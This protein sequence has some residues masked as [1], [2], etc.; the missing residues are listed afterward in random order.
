MFGARPI[1]LAASQSTAFKL[2]GV[3]L[4]EFSC[5]LVRVPGRALAGSPIIIWASGFL[6]SVIYGAKWGFGTSSGTPK[7]RVA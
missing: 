5:A 4:K 3:G 7:I 1:P 2:L 6:E